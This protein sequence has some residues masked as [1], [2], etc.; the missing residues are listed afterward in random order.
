VEIADADTLK[1]IETWAPLRQT[2]ALVAAS[3]SNIRLID[4]LIIKHAEAG[5]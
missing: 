5:N 1:P 4:N 2:V 3:I